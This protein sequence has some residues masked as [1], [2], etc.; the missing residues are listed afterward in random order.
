MVAA[1]M[2]IVERVVRKRFFGV[3]L[4]P[5]DDRYENERARDCV[6]Q[7]MLDLIAKFNR[8]AL[9]VDPPIDNVPQYAAR[10]AHNTVNDVVR[11]RNWTRLKDC[12]FRV[13]SKTPAFARW[14]DPELGKVCGYA[15][16]RAQKQIKPHA[17]MVLLRQKSSELRAEAVL[18]IR[19]DNMGLTHWQTLLDKVFDIAGGP[20]EAA[21]L[22]NFLAELLEIGSEVPL[23]D[24]DY[25]D[26]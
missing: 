17:S 18:A 14:D 25:D 2:P 11:P 9:A 5:R 13:I 20:I 3:S 26:E 15:G 23:G 8:V 16:W 4:S 12:V 19:W 6:Q 21:T 7:A 22:I 1:A 10:T 24:L